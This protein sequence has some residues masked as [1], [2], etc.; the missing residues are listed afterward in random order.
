[1]IGISKGKLA[2]RTGTNSTACLAHETYAFPYQRPVSLLHFSQSV[3]FPAPRCTHLPYGGGRWPSHWPL[4]SAWMS[5]S[6]KAARGGTCSNDSFEYT[7]QIWQI[8][9]F[10]IERYR[11]GLRSDCK[12]WLEVSAG[13]RFC[14]RPDTADLLCGLP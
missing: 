1:V 9:N 11:G 6:L 14:H 12:P 13:A 2:P 5:W 3:S 7:P 4:T 8:P 10:A